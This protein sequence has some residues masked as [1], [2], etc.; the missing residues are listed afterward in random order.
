MVRFSVLFEGSDFFLEGSEFFG[1]APEDFVGFAVVF[2]GVA[3]L[4]AVGLA[5]AL[6]ALEVLS[7]CLDTLPLLVVVAFFSLVV[8]AKAPKGTLHNKAQSNKA[9][10]LEDPCQIILLA[11]LSWH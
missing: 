4:V 5:V 3:G 10:N 7:F 9:L 2:V 1:D 8:C 11:K 6:F